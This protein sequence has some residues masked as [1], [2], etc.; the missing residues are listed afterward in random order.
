MAESSL[1]LSLPDFAA[2]AG[3]ELGFG[4]LTTG[5]T[6]WQSASP[7]VP[8]PTQ[9]ESQLAQ[10]MTMIAK[11]L[12]SFYP[13]KTVVGGPPAHKWS[14]LT[15]LR[16]LTTIGGQTTY[17]LPDDY[18]GADGLWTYPASQGVYRPI[19]RTGIG[20]VQQML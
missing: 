20:E 16:T 12:R 2:Q 18:G 14:F 6:G 10:I 13:A 17:P 15:Q 19:R 8:D 5:W 7:Y 1:S 4:T 11:G 3:R 9:A